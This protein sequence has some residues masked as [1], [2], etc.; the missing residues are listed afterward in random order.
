MQFENLF[1]VKVCIN[2]YLKLLK[3]R[4][5]IINRSFCDPLPSAKESIAEGRLQTAVKGVKKHK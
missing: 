1:Q 5:L 4:I 3:V 2:G